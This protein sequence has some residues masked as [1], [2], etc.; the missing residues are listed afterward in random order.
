MLIFIS[1][2]FFK[3]KYQWK[4]LRGLRTFGEPYN[5]YSVMHYNDRTKMRPKKVRFP[6]NIDTTRATPKARPLVVISGGVK[7][8]GC[9]RLL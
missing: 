5:I 9:I 2:F 6:T 8:W 3:E 7:I 1:I 4:I